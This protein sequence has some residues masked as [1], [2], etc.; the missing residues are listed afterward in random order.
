MLGSAQLAL[1]TGHHPGVL[2]DQVTS[3]GGRHRRPRTARGR[4][5]RAAV[6]EAVRAAT[7]SVR[8]AARWVL[9]APG[10]TAGGASGR[11]L[12]PIG[13]LAE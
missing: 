9:G 12:K 11:F 2:K 4:G 3:P 6:Y 1:E 10:A 7:G 8:G 13:P 5:V